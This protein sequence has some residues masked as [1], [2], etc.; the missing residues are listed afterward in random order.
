MVRKRTRLRVVT[1]NVHIARRRPGM[2]HRL[3]RAARALVH[4]GRR[5]D[6]AV[7]QEFGQHAR[8]LEVPDHAGWDPRGSKPPMMWRQQLL[9]RTSYGARR[10]ARGRTVG[11]V[12]GFRS[13]LD[14]YLATVTR[15]ALPNGLR[16]TVVGLHLPAHVEGPAGEVADTARGTMWT[17]CVVE[18]ARTMRDEVD[19]GADAVIVLGD[20]NMRLSAGQPFRPLLELGAKK[21]RPHGPTHGAREIDG[22]FVLAGPAVDVDVVSC[23]VMRGPGLP[24]LPR[25]WF[26]HRPVHATLE[27]TCK[28][29][30]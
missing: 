18:V 30:P 26:D 6:V 27:I 14:D 13:T 20:W 1:W 29:K 11:R 17:D 7:L 9:A 25:R 10:L 16:V 2:K 3:N 4:I 8:L 5:C 28:E 22:G 15:F 19:D 24:R 21:I 23:H 12:K